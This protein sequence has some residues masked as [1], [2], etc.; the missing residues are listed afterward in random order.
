MALGNERGKKNN[1]KVWSSSEVT[2]IM[3]IFKVNEGL[4][5]N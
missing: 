3:S 2:K 5:D 4:W 1:K